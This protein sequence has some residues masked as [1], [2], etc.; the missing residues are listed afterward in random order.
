MTKELWINLPVKDVERSKQ[1]FTALGFSFN[2]KMSSA[3]E[4]ACLLVG[5]RPTVVML[6][7]EAAFKGFS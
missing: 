6:F 1:F 2:E 5:V 7:A 3:G 4:R